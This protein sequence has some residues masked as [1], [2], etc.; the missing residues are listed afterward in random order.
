MPTY[1]RIIEITTGNAENIFR[2]VRVDYPT[3]LTDAELE[4]EFSSIIATFRARYETS[5][6]F[7]PPAAG[8]S[9]PGY[10]PPIEGEDTW[11]WGGGD[12]DEGIEL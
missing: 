9:L 2:T 6:R 4:V 12:S 8:R 5:M 11:D 1:R 7:V 3:P 10:V